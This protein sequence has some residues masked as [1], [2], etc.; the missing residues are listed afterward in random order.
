[1][2]F[3]GIDSANKMVEFIHKCGFASS[4]SLLLKGNRVQLKLLES[5]VNGC[6]EE[7]CL[8]LKPNSEISQ[9]QKPVLP[10]E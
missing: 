3:S 2:G 8:C 1:M 5:G 10:Q 4:K 7:W 6:G 9:L